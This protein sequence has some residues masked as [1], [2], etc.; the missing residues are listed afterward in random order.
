MAIFPFR[1]KV[2]LLKSES[3]Y[4]TDP[5]PTGAA[6]A[7]LAI[8]GTIALEADKLER[9][10]DTAYFG[11]KPFVLVGRRAKIEFEFEALGAA[12]PGTASPWGALLKCCGFN[13][14]LDPTGPPAEAVYAP[15]SDNIGSAAVYFW[16]GAQNKFVIL[17]CRGNVEFMSDIKTFLKGKTSLTGIMSIPTAAAMP[18]VTLTGFQAPV[19]IETE[20]FEVEF[21]SFML[22]AVGVSLNMGNDVKIH[23]GS[24]SREII[25]NDRKVSGTIKCYDPGVAGKDLWTLAK[26]HDTSAMT[27]TVQPA[28]SPTGR[29]ATFD[30]PAV[31]IELPKFVDIDGAR[32]LEIAYAGIPVTGND[33][34]VVTFQ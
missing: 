26:S 29:I 6:N 23:E 18:A 17:G 19:A 22:N 9:D 13:E 4:G 21:D 28:A 12:T 1:H 10:I 27:Y 5:T 8:K 7:L 25:I 31:Q 2:V 30:L 16:M 33:E 20:T 15:I 34:V 11:A 32:G 14:T 3:S 24:E